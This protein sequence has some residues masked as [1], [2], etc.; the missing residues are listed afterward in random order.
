LPGTLCCEHLTARTEDDFASSP[1]AS[2][3]TAPPPSQWRADVCIGTG[4]LAE[5]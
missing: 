4:K 3:A 1:G 5:R 2:P